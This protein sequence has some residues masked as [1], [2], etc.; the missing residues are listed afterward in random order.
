MRELEIKVA[1]RKIRERIIGLMPLHSIPRNYDEVLEQ[2]QSPD[3]VY[4]RKILAD[5]QYIDFLRSLKRK[6]PECKI[7]VDIFTY[8][9]DKDEFLKWTTRPF[10]FKDRFVRI[11]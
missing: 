4:I 9:Y 11:K 7:V 2:M 3:F 10:Y 6:Y 1:N 8:P 5:K